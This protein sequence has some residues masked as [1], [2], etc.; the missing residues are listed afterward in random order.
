MRPG[1]KVVKKTHDKKN[2]TFLT[3]L[4]S[5]LPLAKKDPPKPTVATAKV[6]TYDKLL[7]NCLV[8]CNKL[9]NTIQRIKI[10]EQKTAS[11]AQAESIGMIE[12]E[13]DEHLCVTLA[14]NLADKICR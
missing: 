4:F 14:K 12:K 2:P 10:A 7:S 8:Q 9:A 1:S 6:L 13:N 11:P 5:Y 3:F